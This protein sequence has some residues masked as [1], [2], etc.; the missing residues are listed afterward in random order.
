MLNHDCII[1]KGMVGLSPDLPEEPQ[2]KNWYRKHPPKKEKT[3]KQ[4]DILNEARK[5]GSSVR[6][7]V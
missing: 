2:L 1:G 4:L 6:V 7:I 3:E 5:R